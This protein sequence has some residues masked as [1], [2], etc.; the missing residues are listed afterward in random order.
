VIQKKEKLKSVQQD[1]DDDFCDAADEDAE[2]GALGQIANKINKFEN[3]NIC[4]VIDYK[5]N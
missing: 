1:E 5:S 3:H 2:A 4:Q